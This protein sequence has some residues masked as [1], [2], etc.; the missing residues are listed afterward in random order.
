[1]AMCS[2][3][4]VLSALALLFIAYNAFNMYTIFYPSQCSRGDRCIHPKHPL[5]SP[6]ELWVY[7]S[8]HA[9]TQSSAR[10]MNQLLHWSSFNRNIS[11]DESVNVTLSSSTLNN[12]SLYAHVFLG[13]KGK[14]PMTSNDVT[15]MS[16]GVVPLTKYSLLR[17]SSFNLLFGIKGSKEVDRVVSHWIPSLS[18]GSLDEDFVFDSHNTPPDLIPYIRLTPHSRPLKY[19]PL[20][21]LDKLQIRRRDLIPLGPTNESVSLLIKYTPLPVGRLRLYGL[22]SG[23]LD[24]MQRLGFTEKEFEDVKGIVLDT[25]FYLF[26]L[27]MLISVF[28]LLF[29]FLAFKNDIEFWRGRKTTAGLATSTIVWR[30]FSHSVVF[31][32]LLEEKT[33]L[34]VIVPSG[35]A[36]IIEYWKALRACKT[37]VVWKGVLPTLERGVKVGSELETAVYD[38]QAMKKLSYLLCPLVLVGAVYQLVYSSYRSWYSWIINSLV[39]GV[40]TFGFLFML[41]QLFLNYK[42]KSVAHLPWRAFM[43]KAFNTFIDDVFAFIIV[44]PTAHRIAVFRDDLV[45]L[46]YLYQ[47]W[48]YPVD[49]ARVNEFGESFETKQHQD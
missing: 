16:V 49:K 33:S 44:M 31:L 47:R 29:D 42:L 7:T 1:M 18:V 30:A 14:S 13:R 9:S 37:R 41:P 27:T 2:L 38:T 17:S 21:Y 19:L 39:N 24:N 15:L 43:Y 11:Q 35:I 5:S 4:R 34:L 45:F 10:G 32:Y 48:L 22:F 36:T 28:H 23:A 6:M 3:S 25:N 46:V 12:G 26:A 20:L 8:P 40:Y